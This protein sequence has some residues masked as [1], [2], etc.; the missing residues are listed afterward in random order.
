MESPKVTSSGLVTLAFFEARADDPSCNV[1]RL[2]LFET[3]VND[4]IQKFSI[5]SFTSADV[6][7]RILDDF[8]VLL[9]Q[10]VV[11]TLLGRAANRHYVVRSSG[12]YALS[13]DNPVP[14]TDL[15]A[16]YAALRKKQDL[17]IDALY[18][19]SLEEGLGLSREEVDDQ[20]IDYLLDNCALFQRRD[21]YEKDLDGKTSL[22]TDWMHFCRHFFK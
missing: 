12:R 4:A 5:A 7:T 17:L 2:D 3:L 16:D 9:P 1:G 15:S 6:Q 19:Y 13:A 8:G 11:S 18:N 10:A 14:Y 22:K 20:F 21:K